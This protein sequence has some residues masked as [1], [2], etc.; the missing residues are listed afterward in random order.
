MRNLPISHRENAKKDLGS[1]WYTINST[2]RDKER[3]T[4][5]RASWERWETTN[6]SR[7]PHC[8]YKG[9]W[10]RDMT[11]FG[12]DF[13]IVQFKESHSSRL[14]GT[15]LSAHTSTKFQKKIIHTCAPQKS[16]KDVKIVGYWYSTAKV[17]SVRWNNVK[18]TPRPSKSKSDCTKS[19]EKEGQNSIPAN[20]YGKKHINR[21]WDSVKEPNELTRKLDGDD[22]PLPLHQVHLRHGGNHEKNGGSIELGWTVIFFD[23]C[24]AYRQWRFSC[25][26][27]V[28]NP[29]TTHAHIPHFRT[30]EFSRV[31]QD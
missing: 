22:I 2:Q 17:Q 26:R 8:G 5:W 11:L 23:F 31:A 18:T 7:S 20:R 30:R 1:I 28:C 15:K 13:R 10:K 16:I 9:K 29:H 4:S 12:N 6:L 21:F 3:S 19:L 14:D 24:S 25:N 27:R